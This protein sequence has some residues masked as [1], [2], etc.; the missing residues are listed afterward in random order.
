MH[1]RIILNYA[2][3]ETRINLKDFT[4]LISI[5]LNHFDATSVAKPDIGEPSF[6][7]S[8]IIPHHKFHCPL[9]K[10]SFICNFPLV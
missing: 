8:F 1:L 3:E 6:Q 2:R 7:G 5:S 9:N 10:H 4:L